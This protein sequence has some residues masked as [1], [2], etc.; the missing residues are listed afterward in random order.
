MSSQL[1]PSQ[2]SRTQQLL[3]S[4]RLTRKHDRWA[5][6]ITLGG[7]VLGLAVGALLGWLLPTHGI[8]G[9]VLATITA[10]ALG[11]LAALFAFSRRAQAA[12]FKSIE[13][14][15]GAAAGALQM[16]K[17][18]W[19]VTPAVGFNKDQ[20]LVHRVVGASGI[21]LVAEGTSPSRVRALLQTEITKTKRVLP[22]TPIHAVVVGD[23]EG[24]VPLK[25][26]TVKLMRGRRELKGAAITDV[27]NR[28]KAL[29]AQRGTLPMPKGP[30]PT[31][32]KGQRRQMRG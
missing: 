25:K 12:A 7:G 19:T 9:W 13:G 3:E 29:D 32:M 8:L 14:Q 5:V 30:V 17:R 24:E 22:E 1:D 11:V 21:T 4:W 27:L 31:S 23:G 6:P 28:L 26:L 16:L 15:P 2:M 20:D 10:V 18:G